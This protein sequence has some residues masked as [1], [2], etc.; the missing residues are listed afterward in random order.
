MLE[1]A[2]LTH[3]AGRGPKSEDAVSSER[4]GQRDVRLCRCGRR[5]WMRHPG[6]RAQGDKENRAQ[7]HKGNKGAQRGGLADGNGGGLERGVEKNQAQTAAAGDHVLK[8]VARRGAGLHMQQP[9][10]L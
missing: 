5:R 6:A 10:I 2:A 1:A 9:T 4:G 7:G 3:L 8:N